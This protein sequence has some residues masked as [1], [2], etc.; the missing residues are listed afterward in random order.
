MGKRINKR[1]ISCPVSINKKGILIYNVAEKKHYQELCDGKC[2]GK[3][4]QIVVLKAV[5]SVSNVFRFDFK[6]NHFGEVV[7]VKYNNYNNLKNLVK[8]KKEYNWIVEDRDFCDYSRITT[9]TP[10][11][12]LRGVQRFRLI[13]ILGKVLFWIVFLIGLSFIFIRGILPFITQLKW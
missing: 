8:N 3:P 6:T 12:S 7:A 10:V 13:K 2:E 1:K 9:N 5:A 4:H 11:S